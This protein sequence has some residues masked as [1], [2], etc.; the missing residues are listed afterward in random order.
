[1]L[2]WFPGE[3]EVGGSEMHFRVDPTEFSVKRLV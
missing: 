1:M 2:A 3:K